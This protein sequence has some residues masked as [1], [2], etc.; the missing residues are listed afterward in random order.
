MPSAKIV[1]QKPFGSVIPPLSPGRETPGGLADAGVAPASWRTSA[2]M[3]A[4]NIPAGHPGFVDP[5]GIAVTPDGE[6]AHK[7]SRSNRNPRDAERQPRRT[8]GGWIKMMR[9]LLPFLRPGRRP[10]ARPGRP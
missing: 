4:I 10:W 3:L 8:I 1:A 9:K 5:C 6:A 7:T 2:R